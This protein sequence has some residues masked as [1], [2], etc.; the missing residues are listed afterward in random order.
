MSFP[1][2]FTDKYPTFMGFP[3]IGV[4]ITLSGVLKAS[5]YTTIAFVRS[6]PH[7]LFFCRNCKVWYTL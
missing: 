5:R 7:C 1:D 4:R 2:L 3:R 6:D